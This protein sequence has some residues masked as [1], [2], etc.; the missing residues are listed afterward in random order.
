[1]WEDLHRPF[2]AAA[3]IQ[4]DP[5]ARIEGYRRAQRVDY[6]CELAHQKAADV[7]RELARAARTGRK[8]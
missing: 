1:M 5:I 3:D 6:G 4:V 7:A 2:L 8:S